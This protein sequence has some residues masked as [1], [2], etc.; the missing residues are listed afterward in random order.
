[1]RAQVKRRVLVGC[2]MSGKVRD[3]FAK[4]GWEA[5]S[6]DV[7]PSESPDRDFIGDPLT[8]WAGMRG[9]ARH[10]QG[11]VRD[12]FKWDHPVNAQRKRDAA[13]AGIL[14]EEPVPLW[15]LFAGFPPCTHLAQ[16]GA[17]WW[18]HKDATRGGD[19]RMQEGAAFFMEMVNAPARYVAVENP[20][21]VMGN[22]PRK[23]QEPH[24]CFYRRPDQ[25]VQPHMFG[26]PLIKA[27][28]IWL[29]H[30][31]P[32]L[33]ADN[34]V[35]PTGR[36]A[37][38][39]GSCRTDIAAGRDMKFVSGHEDAKGRVHRQRERNRTLP[40]LARAMAEQWTRFTEEL[41]SCCGA[42][43]TVEGRTTRYWKCSGCGQACDLGLAG[44]R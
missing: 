5:V 11:D 20:V 21:G 7:L 17:V 24:P 19:G 4:R 43:V 2:E 16:A 36:V 26:D 31:L 39:G 9:S 44:G 42:R 12:L 32:P 15:D 22:A 8:R 41:S 23:G 18:K 28:C 13:T 33:V 40:G 34:P 10:Y 14:R 3:E 1:V 38:G 29:E 30:G 25:V 37:S 27:T 6:A 35:E